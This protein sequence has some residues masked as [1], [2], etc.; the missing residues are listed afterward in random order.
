MNSFHCA[1]AVTFLLS[2]GE[3]EQ[4]LIQGLLV[5]FGALF[6]VIRGLISTR[7]VESRWSENPFEKNHE[8]C[9]PTYMF[10][11]SFRDLMN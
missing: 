6:V 9:I 11:E 4:E 3:I 8:N 5:T 10:L 1:Q 7:Q 2:H